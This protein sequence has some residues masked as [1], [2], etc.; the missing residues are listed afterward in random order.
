MISS[1]RQNIVVNVGIY[2]THLSKVLKGLE[3][4]VLPMV[5]CTIKNHWGHSIRVGH[6]PNFGLSVT[7]YCHA[8]SKNDVKQNSLTSTEV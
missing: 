3:C 2:T 1:G 7:I 4:A 8:C 6:S 5:L